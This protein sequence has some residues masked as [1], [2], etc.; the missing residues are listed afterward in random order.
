[1]PIGARSRS[2]GDL[3]FVSGRQLSASQPIT[4]GASGSGSE[5][6]G[7][8]TNNIQPDSSADWASMLRDVSRDGDGDEDGN[9]YGKGDGFGAEHGRGAP[10]LRIA[11]L[12]AGVGVIGLSLA[13][14]G[15]D[16]GSS[17]GVLASRGG[18]TRGARDG[19]VGGASNERA[20]CDAVQHGPAGSISGGTGGWPAASGPHVLLVEKQSSL[21]Q[22]CVRNAALN[23]VGHRVRVWLGDVAGISVR[24]AGGD[25]FG[26]EHAGADADEN[27]DV[28]GDVFLD[29]DPDVSWDTDVAWDADVSRDAGV[30]G[31]ANREVR[32]GANV[33]GDAAG[34]AD[35]ASDVGA[36]A[37]ADLRE[38]IGQ[39]DAVVCNR[40]TFLP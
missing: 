33:S 4:G 25:V 1:M 19:P 7:H 20:P 12:G 2:A 29:A 22:R 6:S 34:D 36:G 38:W 14:R 18:G 21:A 9:L 40:H 35:V 26:E 24:S 16:G 27:G 15:S 37:A 11:D 13:V 30:S 32:K 10:P 23:G 17:G 3:S 28:D 39:C 5:A 8:V 31:S